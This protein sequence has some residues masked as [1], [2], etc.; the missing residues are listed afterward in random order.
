MPQ[1]HHFPRPKGTSAFTKVKSRVVRN[2][3]H[4]SKQSK[5]GIR[6]N[7]QIFR[8][9]KLESH[10]KADQDMLVLANYHTSEVAVED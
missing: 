2:Y 3:Y 9:Q 6:D 4:Y 8:R 5:V 7:N 10:E 1:I